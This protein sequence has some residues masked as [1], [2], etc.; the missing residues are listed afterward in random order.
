MPSK[1]NDQDLMLH[2]RD[3]DALAFEELYGRHKGPVYRYLLR[4]CGN[5]ANAEEIFQ[6]V[7]IKVIRG[8]DKYRPLA[9]FSTWLYQ[10]AHNCFIDFV[11]RQDRNAL[12]AA[13][14]TEPDELL[15]ET[16]N[17]ERV[18]ALSQTGQ[19]LAGAIAA[20]PQEQREAFLLR[21]EGGFGLEEIAS[22]TDTGRETVKSR[23]RYA[24]RKL[25]ETL[26]DNCHE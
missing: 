1:L 4:Q 8:R 3:G 18:A 20:L 2:Y 23:L 10:I 24:T 17:P 5:P 19:K 11:R 25:R 12:N 13:S 6:E 7:W 21:V 22:I 15:T 26:E 9:K 16:G 14:N